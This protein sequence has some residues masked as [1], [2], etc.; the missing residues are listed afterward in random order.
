[1]PALW[2]A[3]PQTCTHCPTRRLP[4]PPA[5]ARPLYLPALPRLRPRLPQLRIKSAGLARA[6][7]ELYLG[8]GSVVPEG[9]GAWAAG[10]RELLDSDSVNRATRKAGSG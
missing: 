6:L 1:M 7:F 3:F 9:R 2:P 8:D 5:P 10:A 4:L